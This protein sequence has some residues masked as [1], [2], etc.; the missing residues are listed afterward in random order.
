V[1]G[2]GSI[3]VSAKGQEFYGLLLAHYAVRA[4]M[5]EAAP[6]ADID[7]DALSFIHAVRVVRR[8]PPAFNAIPPC[9]EESVP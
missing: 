8:K 7:P 3:R 6:K 2:S 9:A 1:S 4:L 5:H